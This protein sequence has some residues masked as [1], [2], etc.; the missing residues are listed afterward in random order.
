MPLVTLLVPATRATSA[1]R[2]VVGAKRGAL[3]LFIGEVVNFV[4]VAF[5]LLP[6]HREF[7][8]FVMKAKG[9]PRPRLRP[10][11]E[12]ETLLAEIRDLLK[13]QRA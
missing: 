13:A 3:R 5:V 9:R 11:L 2:F 12:G 4:I 10:L 7:L 1:G 6:L 8:G